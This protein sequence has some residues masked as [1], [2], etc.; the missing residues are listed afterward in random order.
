MQEEKHVRAHPLPSFEVLTQ[1]CQILTAGLPPRSPRL[2]IQYD[3]ECHD[4]L[5][6]RLEEVDGRHWATTDAQPFI[7][8]SRHFFLFLSFFWTWKLSPAGGFTWRTKSK[9]NITLDIWMLGSSK[10][11]RIDRMEST[12]LRRGEIGCREMSRFF[13]K[14]HCPSEVPYVCLFMYCVLHFFAK[15]WLFYFPERH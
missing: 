8:A 15:K 1:D 2:E 7:I 6:V 12:F 3:R 4:S 13:L 14:V 5:Q 10:G 11:V 9:H